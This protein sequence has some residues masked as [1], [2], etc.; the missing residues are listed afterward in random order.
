MKRGM[1]V[2]NNR[3]MKIRLIVGAGL[4]ALVMLL[5]QFVT[6]NTTESVPV[7]WYVR[8]LETMRVDSFV[9]FKIED[10]YRKEWLVSDYL[11]KKIAG[12]PGDRVEISEE[13]GYVVNGKY[14]GRIMGHECYC[15]AG[16][17]PEGFVFVY[18]DKEDS[19]D[20]RYFGPVKIA[21]INVFKRVY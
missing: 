11:L 9:R 8:S 2:A 20:S 5:P 19:Y 10:Q 7:G 12:L 18:G 14:Y 13:K 16:I 15:F 1:K 3:N 17:I 4:L 6:Y 21:S